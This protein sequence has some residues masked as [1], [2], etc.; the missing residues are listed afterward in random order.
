[1]NSNTSRSVCVSASSCKVGRCCPQASDVNT[2]KLGRRTLKQRRRRHRIIMTPF[3]RTSARLGLGQVPPRAGFPGLAV[4]TPWQRYFSSQARLTSPIFPFLTAKCR[5]MLARFFYWRVTYRMPDVKSSGFSAGALFGKVS[6]CAPYPLVYGGGRRPAR[7][8]LELVAVK[9]ATPLFTGFRRSM[10]RR[11]RGAAM[12]GQ[13]GVEDVH[14]G[15][16][17]GADIVY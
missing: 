3:F 1:M 15:F 11:I 5:A 16:N 17:P 2:A 4:S 14:R 12:L 7:G 6:H 9:D 10:T 13:I 8:R